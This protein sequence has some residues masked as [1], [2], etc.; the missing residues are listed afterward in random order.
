MR[1]YDIFLG[2]Q[3]INVPVDK[4]QKIGSVKGNF[5]GSYY[6]IFSGTN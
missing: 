1:G 6:N 3:E 2:D 4:L 5:V